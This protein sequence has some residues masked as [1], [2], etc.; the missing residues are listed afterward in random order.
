VGDR[1]SLPA[2]PDDDT[3]PRAQRGA[4]ELPTLATDPAGWLQDPQR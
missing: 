3:A 1:R 2:D 4:Q